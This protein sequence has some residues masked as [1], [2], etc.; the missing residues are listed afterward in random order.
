M[1]AALPQYTRRGGESQEMRV[2]KEEWKWFG[3]AAHFICARWCRFHLATQVGPWLV[4]TIG[5][6]V[7]PRHSGGSEDAE[8]K[9]LK[10]NWPGEELGHNRKYETMVFKAGP[11]CT[12][13]CGLPVPEDWAEQDFAGYNDA[14]AATE[15]HM[16]MCAEF[17]EASV[18]IESGE[19]DD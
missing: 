1:K 13:G 4:S 9:W 6:Y 7:H 18:V 3:N 12:C 14:A 19:S 16:R 17:A 15:G 2:P 8:R 10:K 11:P 5:E